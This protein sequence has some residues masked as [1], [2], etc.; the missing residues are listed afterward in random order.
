MNITEQ[1][2]KKFHKMYELIELRCTRHIEEVEPRAWFD[3]FE[4]GEDGITIYY[5][6][7]HCGCCSPETETLC[8]DWE[9]IFDDEF[10]SKLEAR[11]Q[12]RIQ[13]ERDAAVERARRIDAERKASRKQQY[14]SLKKEFG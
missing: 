9:D 11:R 8:V 6:V 5:E 13:R 7:S 10:Q 2:W 4:P 12:E 1:E 3:H 14:E